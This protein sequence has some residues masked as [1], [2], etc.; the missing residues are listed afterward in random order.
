MTEGQKLWEFLY[1]LETVPGALT[2]YK[3][4]PRREMQNFGLSARTVKA[5]TS[6]NLPAIR[7]IL[8]LQDV[9]RHVPIILVVVVTPG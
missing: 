7:K 9:T 2:R 5:I 4:S 1:R 6:A 8:G 3:K